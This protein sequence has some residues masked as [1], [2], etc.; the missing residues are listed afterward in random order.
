MWSDFGLQMPLNRLN[1]DLELYTRKRVEKI[2]PY[3][4]PKF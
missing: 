2:P 4:V 1:E 3:S